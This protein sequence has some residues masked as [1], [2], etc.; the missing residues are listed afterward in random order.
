MVVHHSVGPLMSSMHTF[1]L[2]KGSILERSY[3]SM[4]INTRHKAN[5][6]I[7][8]FDDWSDGFDV[9]WALNRLSISRNIR[10]LETTIRFDVRRDVLHNYYEER[11][12]IDSQGSK[13]TATQPDERLL[14]N[15]REFQTFLDR[16]LSPGQ[17]DIS[18]NSQA[19]AFPLR[20]VSS[21]KAPHEGHLRF[22]WTLPRSRALPLFKLVM[23]HEWSSNGSLFAIRV[24]DLEQGNIFHLQ[25]SRE[26]L[27]DHPEMDA[28]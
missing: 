8:F 20:G 18:L 2:R 17:E 25:A 24:S 22:Q 5:D 12:V 7:E 13:R 1:Q 16:Q 19:T 21:I 9:Q 23:E 26:H 3:V 4:H 10:D 28:P 27:A 11:F 14:T 15:V 6:P